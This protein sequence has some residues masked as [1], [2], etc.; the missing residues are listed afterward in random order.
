M[1]QRVTER[2]IGRWA[3][4]LLGFVLLTC[5]PARGE[6]PYPV[7]WMRQLG[8]SGWD[9]SNSV[10]VDGAGNAFISGYTSG[11][12]VGTNAGLSDAFL[13][14][15]DSAGN[16]QWTRQLGTSDFDY[17]NS[18][19][20]DGAGNA[21]ISG[22][23]WGSLVGTNAGS[24]DAFLT[25]YDSAGTWQWTRQLG[26]SS[27]DISR[28][29]AVDGAGNAFIS[30]DTYGSLDGDNAGDSDAFLVKFAVPEPASA[31]ILLLGAVA[32]FRRRKR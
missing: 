4:G 6:S 10:A 26:T 23:T 15:Y 18:V 31:A 30:G 13:S 22:H 19:A 3:I 29:V 11:S 8:T 7:S 2:V 17:S 24:W 20:V 5:G 12:L 1:R 14:K 32:L 27:A 28:S 21:F 16:F 25:K 9:Q